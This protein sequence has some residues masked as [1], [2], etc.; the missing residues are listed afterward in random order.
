MKAMSDEIINQP[1]RVGGARPGAG[2][3]KGSGTRKTAEL[4]LLVAGKGVT[5]LEVMLETMR[6]AWG[7][8]DV[9]TACAIAKDVAPYMHPR[10]QSTELTD[11]REGYADVLKR[12]SERNQQVNA[13]ALESVSPEQQVH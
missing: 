9:S 5:P 4:A 1:K 11:K 6:S 7:K 10:L 3:P 13:V 8:G 2:R 12:V